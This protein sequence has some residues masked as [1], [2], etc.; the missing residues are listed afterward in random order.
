[1]SMH[2]YDLICRDCRVNLSMGCPIND[3]DDFRPDQ[4]I[5]DA[6]I[7][8]EFGSEFYSKVVAKFLILH[9]NH[10]I[11]FIPNEAIGYFEQ[12][13]GWYKP[14]SAEEVLAQPLDPPFLPRQETAEWEK[15]AKAKKAVD[16]N[17]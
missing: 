14:Q 3:S 10:R 9:R 6:I 4:W 15:R 13:D 17:E 11:S 2:N 1:M 16:Q 12:L 5:L 7:D 8:M